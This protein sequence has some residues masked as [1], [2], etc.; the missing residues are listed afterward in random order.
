MVQIQFK[1]PLIVEFFCI[2]YIAKEVLGINI[3]PKII[4]NSLINELYSVIANI[5]K[6]NLKSIKIINKSI[7]IIR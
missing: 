7:I 1:M 5:V 3:N 4:T 6:L 2:I